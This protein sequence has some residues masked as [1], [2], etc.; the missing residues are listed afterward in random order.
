MQS[1][2]DAPPSLP[3][4]CWCLR[5][6]WLGWPKKRNSE[7]QAGAILRNGF[8]RPER[9]PQAARMPGRCW[10]TRMRNCSWLCSPRAKRRSQKNR[11]AGIEPP[12]PDKQRRTGR[13]PGAA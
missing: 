13:G 4:D 8:G 3:S 2:K 9:T 7:A 6:E 10:G 12:Q 5:W 1:R 11:P